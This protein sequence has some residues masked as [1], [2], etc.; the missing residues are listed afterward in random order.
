MIGGSSDKNVVDKLLDTLRARKSR[1]PEFRKAFKEFFWYPENYNEMR[2]A[3]VRWHAVLS[4]DGALEVIDEYID[5]AVYSGIDDAFVNLNRQ[6]RELLENVRAKG[7][8]RALDELRLIEL[9]DA[10]PAQV[11]KE[12]AAVRSQEQM[13]A[14]TEKYPQVKVFY[15]EWLR[16]SDPEGAALFDEIDLIEEQVARLNLPHEMPERIALNQRAIA[17][18]ET[19]GRSEYWA[20][21]QGDLAN[22]HAKNSHGKRSE[23]IDKALHHYGLALEFFNRE[24]YPF[25]WASTQYNIGN[26]YSDRINGDRVDNEEQAI[27]H[28]MEAL[29][30]IRRERYT[31]LWADIQHALGNCYLHRNPD[32]PKQRTNIERA[33]AYLEAAEQ[34][35]LEHPDAT[36]DDRGM[37]SR[38]LG[39][40]YAALV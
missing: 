6:R 15:L 24:E 19:R 11:R 5:L 18:L 9:L 8:Q 36:D 40:A 27:H 28:Y 1:D 13:I 20:R 29:K 32:R 25:E 12:I 22:N 38:S 37:V 4:S 39:T 3:L 7:L 16:Q 17:L 33:I 23:N 14:L 31:V 10:L 30:E 2:V 21:F 35:Y 26:L 34:V